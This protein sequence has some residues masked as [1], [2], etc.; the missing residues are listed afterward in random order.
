MLVGTVKTKKPK[1][2][3][4]KGAKSEACRERRNLGRT[5]ENEKSK[6]GRKEAKRRRKL[7]KQLM[8]L[9]TLYTSDEK[10]VNIYMDRL[11]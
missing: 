3:E 5:R 1:E 8:F 4:R 10:R 7:C 11:S 9:T 2:R 6:S